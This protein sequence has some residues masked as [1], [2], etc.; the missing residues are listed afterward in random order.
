MLVRIEG[1]VVEDYFFERFG[2]S[3]EVF[4]GYSFFESTKSIW[5]CSAT[6]K[7]ALLGLKRIEYPGI[8]IIRKLKGHIFKPTTYALQLLADRATK[9][10]IV[11]DRVQTLQLLKEGKIKIDTASA[12]NG[13]V[14]IR[15]QK[16]ILGCG[17]YREGLLK[18]QFPR[19]RAEAMALSGLI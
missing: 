10:I 8:R 16:D 18:G 6:M 2:I 3:P 13:Y 9:N 11:L 7:P 4:R 14:I 17:F 19:G 1:R 5:T 15:Y 12:D